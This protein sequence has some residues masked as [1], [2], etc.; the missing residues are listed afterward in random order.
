[1]NCEVQRYL[2]TGDDTMKL[3]I[4]LSAM[5]AAL[6]IP[7]SLASEETNEPKAEAPEA[8]PEEKAPEAEKPATEEKKPG[9]KKKAQGAHHPKGKHH[10]KAHHEGTGSPSDPYKEAYDGPNLRGAD[11]D[12]NQDLSPKAGVE[13]VPGQKIR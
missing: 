1:M 5:I 9:K 3:P 12:V 7:G 10:P 6:A 2:S 11:G 4:I 13:E 8:A